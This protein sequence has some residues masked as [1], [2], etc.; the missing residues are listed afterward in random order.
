MTAAEKLMPC[1][2]CN[3]DFTQAPSYTLPT[4][5]KDFLHNCMG[6]FIIRHPDWRIGMAIW[7]N[8]YCWQQ[9]RIARE[10]L[11][12]IEIGLFSTRN[13]KLIAA[14]TLAKMGKVGK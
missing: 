13:E 11:E 6:G 10:A 14:Q 12:A 8:A 2:L 5:E 9:L 3:L 4:T 7:N 1:P